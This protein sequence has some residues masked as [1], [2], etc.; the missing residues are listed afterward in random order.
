M[1]QLSLIFRSFGTCYYNCY[2]SFRVSLDTM[3]Q[4]T[5]LEVR[6]YIKNNNGF[7]IG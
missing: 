5:A 1:F 7:M 6:N 2:I 3:P 4:L